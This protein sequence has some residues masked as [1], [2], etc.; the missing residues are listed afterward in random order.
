[1]KEIKAIIRPHMLSKVMEALHALPYFP[2]VTVS[3]C[4]GQGRGRGSGGRFEA[5]EE[6][7]YFAKMTKLELF[8]SDDICDGIVDTICKAAHTGSPDDGLV[9]VIDLSRLVSIRTGKEKEKAI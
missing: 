1:M 6:T 8:C 9:A 5:T 4:Q 7:I 3:D 2:G